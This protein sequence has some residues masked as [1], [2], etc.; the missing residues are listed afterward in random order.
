MP[1]EV[2]SDDGLGWVLW[3]EPLF[4]I[5]ILITLGYIIC[6]FLGIYKDKNESSK[7]MPFNPVSDASAIS[8]PNEFTKGNF[9][10][11]D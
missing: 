3:E 6:L 1:E 7:V 4:W 2:S 5:V 9:R 11:D 8:H 10:T